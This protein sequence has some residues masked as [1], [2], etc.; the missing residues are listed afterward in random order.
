MILVVILAIADG[1]LLWVMGHP[2]PG[3][4]AERERGW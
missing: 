3:W 4:S 1:V 2:R